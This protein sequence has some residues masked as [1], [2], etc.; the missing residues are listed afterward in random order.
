MRDIGNEKTEIILKRIEDNIRSEYEK[1]QRDVIKKLKSYLTQFEEE[2]VL[3]HERLDQGLISIND[4]LDWRRRHILMNKQWEDMRDALAV[5]LHNVN[6]I[7]LRT[8]REQMP[9]IF[10]LNAN[11]AAYQVERDSGIDTGFTL[12]NR[13]AAERLLGKQVNLLPAPSKR[14]A[15]ELW[16]NPDVKWNMKNVQSAVL[17]GIL[18]GESMDKVAKRLMSVT[19]MNYHAAIRNART[20]TTSAQNAGREEAYKQIDEKGNKLTIIW[21]STL[22]DRTRHSHRQMHGEVKEGEYFSN[23]LRYPGDPEGD[24]SEVYN[25]RCQERA[26]IKG[27]EEVP[28]Y[29]PKMGDKSFEE[30]QN[31]KARNLPEEEQH[32]TETK[33]D[34]ATVEYGELF[35]EKASEITENTLQKMD[36]LYPI[37]EPLSYV[38]DVRTHRGLEQDLEAIDLHE[39]YPELVPCGA[40]YIPSGNTIDPSGRAF[41]E[42]HD[43]TLSLDSLQKEFLDRYSLREKYDTVDSVPSRSD[44]FDT[45][46]HSLEGTIIHERAHAYADSHGFFG[47][48]S[49]AHE[50]L[51][52]FWKTHQDE[53]LSISKYAA[54]SPDEMFAEAVVQTF[55]TEHQNTLAYKLAQAII[56]GAKERIR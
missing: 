36:E 7:A 23:G 45:V 43:E 11:Y 50:F 51:T 41:I 24:P 8:A 55:D 9:E 48:N 6:K 37:E 32:H 20:M 30:W 18:Q 56:E 52:E 17:Q 14:K 47:G 27:M 49:E 2:D 53:L 26:F 5:D 29:S 42:I 16:D 1:A 54:S 38:G 44:C 31:E 25:C 3:Q 28:D 21:L 19:E 39:S 34:D 13:Q 46:S 12:Y 22:D 40:Q 35:S 33:R 10:S 4:Y 15:L